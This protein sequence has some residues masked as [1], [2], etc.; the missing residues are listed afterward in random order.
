MG[1][2][3]ELAGRVVAVSGAN[4]GIGRA[5]V[6]RF[7]AAGAQVV[8]L[9]RGATGEAAVRVAFPEHGPAIE[10]CDLTEPASVVAAAARVGACFGRVDVL[11]NNAGIFLDR[12]VPA[13]RMDLDVLRATLET[14]L[15]G[16]VAMC[17]AFAPLIPRGGRILNVSSTM[18]QLDGGITPD[19]A[20]YSVSKTALNAYTSALAAALAPREIMVD[21]LHPG[22][23]RTDMGGAGAPLDPSEATATALFLATRPPGETGCFW[24]N[25]RKIP[26]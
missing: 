25:A 18:G 16:A 9:V 5:L 10:R 7:L 17:R 21:A 11:V 22:W 2:A 19:G 6:R 26:W 1:P 8:A 14:N 4:R 23:V 3:A 13:D 15:V 24:E 20:A 12:G